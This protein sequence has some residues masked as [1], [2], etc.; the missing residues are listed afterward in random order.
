M[1]CKV[2]NRETQHDYCEVCGSKAETEIPFEVHWCEHCNTPIIKAS[3]DEGKDICPVCGGTAPYLSSDLRPVFPQER[4]L[5]EILTAKP[6][7]YAEHSVWAQDNRYY[8]DGKVKP[9]PTKTFK[10]LDVSAIIADLKKY[11]KENLLKYQAAFDQYIQS[12]IEANQTH[13]VYI[14]N[15]AFVFIQ[16]AA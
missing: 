3:N 13:L 2:C 5:I 10:L 14:E 16:S 8:I 7:E 1:W 11:E 6:F 9:V 12:F 15:E 4:L